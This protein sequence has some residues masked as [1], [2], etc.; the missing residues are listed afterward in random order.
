MGSTIAEKILSRASG[1]KVVKAGD[2]VTAEI[3]MLMAG[4]AGSVLYHGMND[5]GIK[6]RDDGK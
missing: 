2:Y 5:I 3:D 4:G 1:N 6:K